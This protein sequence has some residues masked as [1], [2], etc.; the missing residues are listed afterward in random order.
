MIA[1]ISLLVI[2]YDQQTRTLVTIES[3]K[4]CIETVILE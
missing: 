4:P 1:N 3:V 2:H